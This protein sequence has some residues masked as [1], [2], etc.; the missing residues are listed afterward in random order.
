MRS[1]IAT[2]S[3]LV[4]VPTTGQEREDRSRWGITGSFTPKWEFLHFL[5]DAM[6]KS[7]DMTGDE[8]RLGVVR[9]RMLG[10]DWGVTYVKRRV[11]DGS[12]M[13]QEKPKCVVGGS[14]P[15]LCAG[16]NSYQTRGAFLQGVQM[17]RFFPLATI[18]DRV[19][20]GAIVSGGIARI[21]GQADETQEHLRVSTDAAGTPQFGVGTE[22]RLVEA[23]SM[24][25]HTFVA[26]HLPIG[27]VEAAVAVSA[28][29]GLKLRV[30]GGAAFPGFHRLSVAA[31]YLFGAR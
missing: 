13:V 12:S 11:D 23:R 6:D 22:T 9:G 26:E 27:G 20:I 29:P 21:E 2:C 28:A 16:G 7:I 24:F 18:A 4:A 5:E 25:D 19:Q 1:L 17:H 8:L 30:S 14:E 31:V 10:G 15:A 3:L